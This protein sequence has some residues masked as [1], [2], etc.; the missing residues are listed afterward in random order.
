MG[1]TVVD[2][3]TLAFSGAVALCES[4]YDRQARLSHSR[5]GV[6]G[7]SQQNI[8]GRELLV[9]LPKDGYGPVTGRARRGLLY[10]VLFYSS[11][12]D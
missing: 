9:V 12:G 7:S 11:L 4:V 6:C 3:P 10:C 5:H 8:P 2:R 1:A